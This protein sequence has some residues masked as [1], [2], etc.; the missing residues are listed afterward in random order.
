MQTLNLTPERNSGFDPA[1]PAP[2]RVHWAVL[3]LASAAVKWLI[4]ALAPKMYHELLYSLAADAWAFYLCRW[5]QSLNPEAKSPFWC[6]V[7]VIVELTEAALETWHNPPTVI[8]AVGFVLAIASIVLGIATIFLIK[9]DLEKHYNER[10]P[11][12]LLLSNVISFFF[13]FFYFQFHLY[14][15]AKQKQEQSFPGLGPSQTP[16][17]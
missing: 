8:I 2:P 1:Y 9:D 3:L 16:L 6:D 7:F 5:I 17:T 12:G 4:A 15:I 13:S 14:R 10:E 11:V